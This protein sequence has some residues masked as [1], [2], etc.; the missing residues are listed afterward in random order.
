[1]AATCK[2]HVDDVA[3]HNVKACSKCGE[4]MARFFNKR[5]CP[6]CKEGIVAAKE[7]SSLG[8]EDLV[9]HFKQDIGYRLQRMDWGHF[10]G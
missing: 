10:N 2:K 8:C 5:L 6:D 7:L 3:D 9:T 1:M 4:M